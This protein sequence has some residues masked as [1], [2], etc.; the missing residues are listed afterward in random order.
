MAAVAPP[1][2][3][4]DVATSLAPEGEVPMIRRAAV[5][6]VFA[7][8]TLL[9]ACNAGSTPSPGA[10]TPATSASPAASESPMSSE[11]PMASSS[12]SSSP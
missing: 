10:S 8:A 9:A 12:P 6:A 3:P 7:L 11:S 4:S 1:S 5:L 2:L